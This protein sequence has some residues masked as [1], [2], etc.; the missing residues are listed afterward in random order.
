MSLPGSTASNRLK[1]LSN[2]I[3]MASV[4]VAMINILVYFVWGASSEGHE[5]YYK[6]SESTYFGQIDYKGWMPLHTLTIPILG[7]AAAANL[8]LVNCDNVSVYRCGGFGM[9]TAVSAAYHRMLHFTDR[10]LHSLRLRMDQYDLISFLFVL[11]P[12]SSYLYCDI[13]RHMQPD[14]SID[15]KVKEISKAFGMV[16]MMSMSVFFLIPV[17]RHGILTRSLPPEKSVRVHIWSGSIAIV[18]AVIHGVAFI[19]RWAYLKNSEKNL[20]MEELFPEMECWTSY[21]HYNSDDCQSVF[22]NLAGL[23]A[24]ICIVVL[25]LFSLKWIRRWRYSLFYRVHI[26]LGP[27]ALLFMIMH[28]ER[29]V[30]YLSPSILYYTASNVPVWIHYLLWHWRSGSVAL[31]SVADLS[32]CGPFSRGLFALTFSMDTVT[33]EAFRPG[34]TV[35]LS[36][37][38]ESGISHPFTVNLLQSSTR[39]T[40]GLIIFRATGKFTKSLANRLLSECHQVEQ[41]EDAAQQP[42]NMTVFMDGFYG[43]QTGLHDVRC[44]QSVLIVAGG[45]GI[46]PYLSLLLE[47]LREHTQTDVHLHWI[48]RDEKLVQFVKDRFLSQLEFTDRSHAGVYSITLHCTSHDPVQSSSIQTSTLSN[49]GQPFSAYSTI[50]YQ[51]SIKHNISKAV[52]FSSLAFSGLFII[53]IFYVRVKDEL[54]LH[55]Q[56]YG[57]LVLVPSSFL[58]GSITLTVTHK[59][60]NTISFWRYSRVDTMDRAEVSK[61]VGSSFSLSE[62]KR[63][64]SEPSEGRSAVND[65]PVRVKRSSLEGRPEAHS[66]VTEFLE[67][68]AEGRK[69]AVFVCG[70]ATLVE[71]IKGAVAEQNVM[72]MPVYEQTFEL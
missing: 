37:P 56:L 50:H 35:K 4:S 3:A 55:T 33:I 2:A 13:A 38:G 23:L 49:R 46:T 60:E 36:L 32:S 1:W 54:A 45:V 20:V 30:L 68:T 48:C 21:E 9:P 53:W 66:I 14:M 70:P 34:M 44:H 69:C 65:N 62:F 18:A 6:V 31:T 51:P 10:V 63:I 8:L 11:L 64:E 15:N 41:I 19:Y 61:S 24:S 58:I 43:Y 27:L 42:S 16:S 22:V 52:V 67:N 7:S 72:Y 57:I 26:L 47:L 40:E 59:I 29:M 5:H 17:T 25:G 71:D 39:T 28:V 12:L